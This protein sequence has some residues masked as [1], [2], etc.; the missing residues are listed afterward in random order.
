M[1][2]YGS[3]EE[4]PSACGF[5]FCLSCFHFSW[6][7]EEESLSALSGAVFSK[8]RRKIAPELHR[9]FEFPD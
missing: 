7:E 3:E 2:V 9:S 8:I 1:E 4:D 5:L 6:R